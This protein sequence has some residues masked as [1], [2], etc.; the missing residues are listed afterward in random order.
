M[1]N[2]KVSQSRIALEKPHTNLGVQFIIGIRYTIIYWIR[3]SNINCVPKLVWGFS[4][5]I[6]LRYGSIYLSRHRRESFSLILCIYLTILRSNWLGITGQVLFF[7]LRFSTDNT[8]FN[9][10]N[11]SDH[12]KSESKNNI[13]LCQFYRQIA[14]VIHHVKL[15]SCYVFW[16]ISSS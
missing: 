12:R 5:A 10:F 14:D 9:L 11:S 6:R 2:I 15:Y 16:A 3:N 1:I 4:Q 8:L 7:L 13:A